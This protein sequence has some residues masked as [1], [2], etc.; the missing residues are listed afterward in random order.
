VTVVIYPEKIRGLPRNSGATTKNRHTEISSTHNNMYI[1]YQDRSSITNYNYS[2]PWK[3][4]VI[5]RCFHCSQEATA[6]CQS[7]NLQLIRQFDQVVDE[8]ILS[9]NSFNLFLQQIYQLFNFSECLIQPHHIQ[10]IQ[11]QMESIFNMTIA[12]MNT[13]VVEVFRRENES[14]SFA[15]FRTRLIDYMLDAKRLDHPLLRESDGYQICNIQFNNNN[16]NHNRPSMIQVPP[17]AALSQ[18]QVN[19]NNT[20]AKKRKRNQLNLHCSA[21]EMHYFDLFHTSTLLDQE[22]TQHVGD[23]P[24]RKRVRTDYVLMSKA[25]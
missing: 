7:Q 1:V 20:T 25:A 4:W 13:L 19:N 6:F 23:E 22:E 3:N 12:D 15:Q 21:D 10:Y 9:N 16:N 5:Q 24:M 8:N 11:E 18:Q 14:E 17:T 2:Q